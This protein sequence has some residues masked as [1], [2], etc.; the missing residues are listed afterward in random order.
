MEFIRRRG[1]GRAVFY[2]LSVFG[3]LYWVNVTRDFLLPFLPPTTRP[4]TAPLGIIGERDFNGLR[5]S[6]GD[7]VLEWLVI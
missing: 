3:T 2:L 7:T 4:G 5:G 1:L 6:R